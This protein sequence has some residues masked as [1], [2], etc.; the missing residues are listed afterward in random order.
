MGFF[1]ELFVKRFFLKGDFGNGFGLLLFG[2]G[3][4]VSFG[5]V[6]GDV[7]LVGECVF[8]FILFDE[9]CEI[10]ELVLEEFSFC[11]FEVESEV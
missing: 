6:G 5:D 11:C 8:L 7:E 10:G 9:Y 3:G 1:L 2:E 4:F